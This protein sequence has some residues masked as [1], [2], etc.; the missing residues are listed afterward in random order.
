MR[1]AVHRTIADVTRDIERWSYNTAVAHCMELLNLLQRYA[2]GRRARQHRP[3][4][5]ATDA[6]RGGRERAWPHAE[7]WNEALDRCSSCSPR[8]RRTSPPS[9]GRRA[10]PASPRCTSSAGRTRPRAGAPGHRDHGGPGQRQGARPHRGR[11]GDLRGG[12]RGGRAGLGQGE[13]GARRGHAQAS[14]RPGRRAWS[15][16]SSE[17]RNRSTT[18]TTTSRR[19]RRALSRGIRRARPSTSPGSTL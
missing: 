7:V 10:T 8:S 13:R 9:S 17:V 14:G 3:P 16:S 6:E 11:R 12:R 1:R 18:P 4:R 15:T 19:R 5:T 2:R